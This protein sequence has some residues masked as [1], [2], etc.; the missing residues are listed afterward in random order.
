[1]KIF[2]IYAIYLIKL[3]YAVYMKSCKIY[4][5]RGE[6]RIENLIYADYRMPI[7]IFAMQHATVDHHLFHSVIYIW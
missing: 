7:I 5:S 1:M 4:I 3:R 2:Y 6:G